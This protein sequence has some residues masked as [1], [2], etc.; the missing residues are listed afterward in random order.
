MAAE[1]AEDLGAVPG[2]PPPTDP[3]GDGAGRRPGRAPPRGRGRSGR[4]D[5]RRSSEIV[6]AVPVVRS[7]CS[8]PPPRSIPCPLSQSEADPTRPFP[9]PS[10]RQT[11]PYRTGPIGAWPS[12]ICQTAEGVHTNS[13][14]FDGNVFGL[15]TGQGVDQADRDF[16]YDAFLSPGN[17]VSRKAA[18][19]WRK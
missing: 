1:L 4:T 10:V 7:R 9:L 12:P 2:E 19:C 14:L 13:E 17:L 3:E 6:A 8:T 11:S 5:R 15:H 16:R 18:I